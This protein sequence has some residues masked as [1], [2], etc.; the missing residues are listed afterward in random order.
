MTALPTK[1][2]HHLIKSLRVT[3]GFLAGAS[4][5]FVDGL[6]CFIGG[7]GAGKTTALE[8]LRFGLGLMPDPKLN[9]ARHRAIEG[10]VKANLGGG[11][12]AVDLRTKTGIGYVAGRAVGEHVQV[13]N[14]QGSPVPVLLDRDQIFSADVF[15]QNEIEEIAANPLAQLELLDRFREPDTFAVAQE[16]SGAHRELEQ[17]GLD[18]R[19]LDQEIVDLRGK[20]S[21]LPSIQERLRGLLT[22]TGPD[23][24]KITAAH[25][26][27]ATRAKQ[28][29][30]PLTAISVVER[31]DSEVAQTQRILDAA[32]T[33]LTPAEAS[34]G[35][36]GPVVAAIEAELRSFARVV[37]GSVQAITKAVGET[38][39]RLRQ[40]QAT[41]A[42]Q[43]SAQELE[44]RT[45]VAQLEE[46]GGR[47]VERSE[48]QSAL[49]E[50]EAA[51]REQAEKEKWRA[52]LLTRRNQILRRVSELRDRRYAIRKAVAEK[53]TLQFPILRVSVDQGAGLDRYCE[54][55]SE[56][57]KGTGMQRGQVATRLSETFVPTELCELVRAGDIDALAT[58]SGLDAERARKVVDALTDGGAVYEIEAIDLDD[59]PRIELKDGQKFK[60]SAQLST[61]Q[62]CTTILPILLVQSERPLVIDQPE[63]NLDNAF[64]YDTVVTALRAVKG[65]RQVIFVTHNPNIPVLG[66]AD[67]VFV[68]RSDGQHASLEQV[69]TVDECKGHIERVL[70]GGREAFLQR[71]ARYGH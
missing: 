65:S 48:F 43:H 55:L 12:I 39:Q 37:A 56:H 7:R 46:E 33:A 60:E 17:S 51:A 11:H 54:L 45:L 35:A 27:K 70:E 15:S 40:H 30:L 38:T 32:V 57:L 41:L 69:G 9:Q 34:A 31:V 66:E 3:G 62:R 67:R 23:A 50:A 6:N 59:H 8:F 25:E 44:Y 24:G 16:L 29:R 4:L 42:A 20:S 63:D 19:R 10:L 61:G 64:V 21:E 58:R 2:P 47:S 14:D 68:F 18:L 53:L 28:E 1:S 22:A 5:D 52:E 71:A 49:A 36:N 13:L 26:A